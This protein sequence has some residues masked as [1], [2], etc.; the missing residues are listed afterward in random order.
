MDKTAW[1]VLPLLMRG[2]GLR[3]DALS[4]ALD[5]VN[6]AS[7]VVSSCELHVARYRGPVDGE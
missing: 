2:M 5:D 1:T 7:A 6:L 3:A 4:S